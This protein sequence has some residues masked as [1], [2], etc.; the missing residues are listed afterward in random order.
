MV[1]PWRAK[2]LFDVG[3]PASQ[4]LLCPESKNKS[5]TNQPH[6]PQQNSTTCHHVPCPRSLP[7]PPHVSLPSTP[8]AKK[9]KASGRPVRRATLAQWRLL[10]DGCDPSV[11]SWDSRGTTGV[12]FFS[13][14]ERHHALKKDL[15]PCFGGALKRTWLPCLKWRGL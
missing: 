14:G 15:F 9:A 1:A 2:E 7:V 12:L 13:R 11:V 3:S 5:T 8:S 4:F 10:T 6:Q